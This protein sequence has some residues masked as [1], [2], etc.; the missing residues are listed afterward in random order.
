LNQVT[1]VDF[2]A[3]NLLSVE[4]ALRHLGAEVLSATTPEAIL[5]AERLILPGVGAFAACME[6]LKSKGLVEPILAFAKTGRPFLGIC[7]GLQ[8]LFDESEEF[9]HHAGLGLIPGRVVRLSDKDS[10]GRKLRVPHIGWNALSRPAGRTWQNTPLASTQPGAS[11]YFVHSF[12]AVPAD[13]AH[14]L[15]DCVYGGHP[16]LAAARKDNITG[17][18]FHPEKSGPAGL[19]LLETFLKS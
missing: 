18:Q 8:M 3:G 2:G 5:A 6:G 10:E 15:A 1:V 7:V 16:V 17:C 19:N 4:R 13:A 12:A 9:G 11:M 14:R